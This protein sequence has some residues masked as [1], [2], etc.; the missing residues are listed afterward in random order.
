MESYNSLFIDVDCPHCNETVDMEIK[1]RFGD[2]GH[3]EYLLGD[4]YNWLPDQPVQSG[5]R[6]EGGNMDGEVDETCPQCGSVFTAIVE[7]RNDII[8]RIIHTYA[9]EEVNDTKEPKFDIK[10][11]I[12][13]PAPRRGLIKNGDQWQLTNRRETALLRLAELGV[14]IYS[15]GGDDFT[16]MVPY[17]L[18][19]DQYIDIGYLIA[20]LGDEDFPVGYEGLTI[21]NT[22]S[23]VF[24]ERIQ[25]NPPVYF[26]DGYPQGLKYRVQPSKE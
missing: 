21:K 1:L 10:K 5:G 22:P 26:V 24:S 7:I 14:D 9:T 19:A 4:Y 3:H 25:G 17:D 6:P 13:I 16:L 23:K 20:Q 18:P 2:V 15:L 12:P 11:Q 8:T